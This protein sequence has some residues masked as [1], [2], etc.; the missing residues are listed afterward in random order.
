MKLLAA[1]AAVALPAGMAGAQSTAPG[2][3]A[4]RPATHTTHST[5]TPAQTPTATPT[6]TDNAATEDAQPANTPNADTAAPA[7]TPPADQPAPAAQAQAA[8][9]PPA[10]APATGDAQ[11]AATPPAAASPVRAATAA[12]L[13]AGVQVHDQTGGV[14]GT[15]ETAD[16]SSAVV[17]TGTVRA[18]LPL[19]SF[20]ANGEGLVISMTRG[21]LEAAA[22]HA[23]PQPH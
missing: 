11:A 21:Q 18:R 23:Q 2:G 13:H 12:D 19:A 9:Q 4:H 10:A 22:S 1:V 14:V 6:P 15:V 20:G 3:G 16:A 5:T 7:Q 8:A 17:S